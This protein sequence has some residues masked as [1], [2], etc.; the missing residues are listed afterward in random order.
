ML[1]ME[2]KTNAL[3]KQVPDPLSSAERGK[4]AF[5]KPFNQKKLTAPEIKIKV[6]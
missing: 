4:R 6:S 5:N 1:N 3:K 2:I